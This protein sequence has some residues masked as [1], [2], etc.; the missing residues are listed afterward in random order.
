M[1]IEVVGQMVEP[2]LVVVGIGVDEAIRIA[3]QC[4]YLPAV[5]I[6][7]L[8]ELFDHTKRNNLLDEAILFVADE[9][10]AAV[11]S[12]R[13][14]ARVNRLDFESA[15][16]QSFLGLFSVAVKLQIINKILCFMENQSQ[17]R[18]EK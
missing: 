16:A 9:K 18:R 8:G 2:T 3:R 4:A 1:H 17:I 11:V 7:V 6:G 15:I 5:V 14:C 13:V 12:R 10:L